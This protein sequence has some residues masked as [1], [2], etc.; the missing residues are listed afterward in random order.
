MKTAALLSF[1]TCLSVIAM[2]TLQAASTP[3]SLLK[4]NL[5]ELLDVEIK[6]ASGIEESLRDAPA[7]ILVI[8]AKDIKRRGYTSLDQIFADLPGF[9]SINAGG[10]QHLIAY[11]RGYRTPF[12]QRTLFMINGITD[13]H[14]WT[15]GSVMS[16]QYP[17]SGIERIE[18]LYGPT[19]AVY[20]PNAFLGIVNIITKNAKALKNK[21]H[22][23]EI[24]L[25]LGSY[26]S[27]GIDA[28]V[29]GRQDD[30]HYHFS[31]KGFVSDEASED[32]YAPWGFLGGNWLENRDVWGAVLDESHEGVSYGEFHDPTEDWGVLGEVG[33]KD[34]K[35]GLIAWQSN[36]GYGPYYSA[37]HAQPNAFW[38]HSSLQAYLQHDWD[39]SEQLNIKTLALH[40]QNQLW[41]EWLEASVDGDN[42]QYSYLSQ[43]DWNSQSDSWLF[44]QDY[45]YQLSERWRFT[46]GIKY[47]KKTLT[48]AYDL[49][50]Y[51]TGAY[52]STDTGD[53]GAY[54]QG[55]GIFHSTDP[56]MTVAPGTLA[57]VPEDNLAHTR[58]IGVYVQALWQ[59]KDWH[60]ASGLRYDRNSMYGSTINPRLSAI[61]RWS[62]KTT[63]KLLYGEAF[64]EPSPLQLWG[65]WIGRAG[66]PDLQPENA[67]NLEFIWLYQGEHWLHDV[68]LFSA[69][70]SNVIKEEAENAGDRHVWGLEYRGHFAYPNFIDNAPDINGYIY[71]SYTRSQSS[72]HYDHDNAQWLEGEAN[73][74]DIAPHKINLG[75]EIP[76]NRHWHA[77]LRAN[78]VS[79]RELYLRNPL[80]N[81]GRKADAYAVFHLALGYQKKPW[82]LSFRI[83]NLF[84][85]EYYQPGV[86]QADSGDDFSQRALGFRNSLIPQPK[87]S[88][89]LRLNWSWD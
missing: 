61:Y 29:Q 86:E 47:E 62:N 58:D 37:D 77:Y 57:N 16:R 26:Q 80:R 45:D 70:Y 27:R 52:C 28:S 63:F 36:E 11:Q 6:S 39:A 38:R 66:N 12:M 10:T 43:S 35:L 1:F 5:A 46:G 42:E 14:L 65:G 73:L 33:F 31:A 84:N 4:M 30:W 82:G 72:I 81:Q 76:F 64:Q 2:N 17:L 25:E 13:N 23:G 83:N 79:K 53:T 34:L 8:S 59:Y 74:G 56:V 71:Y 85:N 9:D 75:L 69:R 15:H 3:R 51:W 48:K 49:C 54:G 50:S 20:G 68:S 22:Q 19:S 55:A 88:Y 41:G 40:R 7:A 87:R 60:L 44:K 24:N 32:D 89:W 67:K 18:V 78:Y 21:Q